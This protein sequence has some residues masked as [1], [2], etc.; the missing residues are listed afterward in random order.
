MQR[1]GLKTSLFILFLGLGL[2]GRAEALAIHGGTS[3][4]G[5][6]V[7]LSGGLSLLWASQYDRADAVAAVTG[8][9]SDH[10]YHERLDGGR[11]GEGLSQGP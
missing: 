8:M 10:Q 1:P 2:V 7:T 9:G 3:S 6:T 11:T 4:M 5:L